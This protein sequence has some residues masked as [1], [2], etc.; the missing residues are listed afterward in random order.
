MIPCVRP[1]FLFSTP[2]KAYILEVKLLALGYVLT[3]LS[4]LL[5]Y[6]ASQTSIFQTYHGLGALCSW[7][8]LLFPWTGRP[9]SLVYLTNS[10]QA[11]KG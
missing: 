5:M 8:L 7:F 11:F 2:I 9:F 6:P 1:G 3:D 10:Y 4:S